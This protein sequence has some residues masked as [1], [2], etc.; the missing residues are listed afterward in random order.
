MFWLSGAIAVPVLVFPA[1]VKLVEVPLVGA[2]PPTQLVPVVQLTFPPPPFQ[3]CANA[4]GIAP[5]RIRAHRNRA[6]PAARK[7]KLVPVCLQRS[8]VRSA[9]SGFRAST[10]VYSRRTGT[11]NPARLSDPRDWVRHG[12]F[13]QLADYV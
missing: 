6:M 9:H 5:T 13:F 4:A 7:A 10:Y 3:V 12:R 8:I 11:W 1:K 2:T